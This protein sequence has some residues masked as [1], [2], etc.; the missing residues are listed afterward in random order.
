MSNILTIVVALL[1]F[2]LMV[3]VHE[4]GHFATAKLFK[5]HVVEFAVGMGPAI[6]KKKR[7]ETTYSLRCIPFGGYCMFDDDVGETD[8]P[9]SFTNAAWYKRLCVVLAGAF[10]NI[11]LG[12]VV[13]AILLSANET[14]Y[15]PVIT[16]FVANA[17]IEQSSIERGDEIVS[18]NNTEI[19]IK[20]DVDFFMQRNGA[21]PVRVTA[22]RNGQTVQDTVSPALEEIVYNYT[23]TEI[24]LVQYIN[25]K[26][27]TRIKQPAPADEE[28][29]AYIGQS[30]TAS[31]YL[32]G[33]VGTQ[34]KHTLGTVLHDAFYNT[35]FNVKIVYIS[36]FDL[37]RGKVTSDQVSGPIG[38]VNVIGQATRL[39]LGTLLSL[40]GL[41]TVNL[42]IMNLLPI[43][44]L[45]GCK[46][47]TILFE[48]VTRKRIPEK[49][50]GY[51]NMAGF[52]LLILLMLWATFNDV[53]NLFIK[54]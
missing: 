32:I 11:V 27:V 30:A 48:A 54:P 33:F 26:E 7:G 42:G 34:P 35:I 45:D 37:L 29:K 3:V 6:F 25:G 15:R 17:A 13:Y 5:I 14:G 38:I 20:E 28:Y 53:Q 22:K 16:D 18:L 50:E 24:E 12:F 31:R 51:I 1:V 9:N 52:A 2:A 46:A 19:H 49:I 23:E 41:L 43:P 36:L 10:L 44:G 39:G 4:F 47:V 40:V 21:A 8:S